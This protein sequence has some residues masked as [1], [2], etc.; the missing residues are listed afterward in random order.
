MGMINWLQ[1]NA[2]PATI[3]QI[4][5]FWV[6][7]QLLNAE[8]VKR[9]LTASPKTKFLAQLSAMQVYG[10]EVMQQVQET[11][12]VTEAEVSDYYNQN[13]DTDPRFSEPERI[14]FTHILLKTLDE[15]NAA[16]EKVKAGEDMGALARQLSKSFDAAIGGAAKN[17]AANFVK[18]RYGK[19]VYDV[20]A[21]AKEGQLLGPVKTRDGFEVVRFDG[22]LP[23][24]P[25][26][27]ESVK[28]QIKS[29]LERRAKS[30]SA[31]KFISSLKEKAAP[32]IQKSDFLIQAE[33][34][35]PPMG[36]PGMG[37]R[38][39]APQPLSPPSSAPSAPGPKVSVTPGAASGTQQFHR[40]NLDAILK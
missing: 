32:D 40:V 31:D 16:Q 8:A 6:T 30:T 35:V 10:R 39:G 1:P 14:S 13:K 20:L 34:L 27:L 3:K 4:A 19:E 29:D 22:K 24:G 25:K 33:K 37:P 7:T 12:A 18:M 36:A 5:D 38:G 26:P 28:D 21:D 9:N 23:A 2:Q 15:A 17:L 11:A